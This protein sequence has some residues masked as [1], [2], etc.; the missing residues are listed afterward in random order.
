MVSENLVNS[1]WD[2]VNG[3]CSKQ[4]TSYKEANAPPNL[5]VYILWARDVATVSPPSLCSLSAAE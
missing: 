1:F 5:Y 4:R 3:F 2:L